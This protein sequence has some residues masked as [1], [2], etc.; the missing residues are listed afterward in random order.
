VTGQ[1]P[2]FVELGVARYELAG[3]EGGPLFDP[4]AHGVEPDLI[5]SACWRG[6][7]CWYRIKADRMLLRKVGLGEPSA[8]GREL[9]AG[10]EV[11]GAAPTRMGTEVGEGWGVDGLAVPIAFT[12]GLLLGR[13][14]VRETYVH[15]GFPAAWQYE[16]VVE[17]LLE[18]GVVTARR[19][20]PPSSPSS[21]SGS[22]RGASRAG[23]RTRDGRVDRPD[24]HAR[25]R[26]QRPRPGHR[27]PAADLRPRPVTGTLVE[28]HTGAPWLRRGRFS[29]RAASRG[30]R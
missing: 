25:L 3:V 10:I 23:R 14:F 21:A 28:T 12:G 6:C 29:G 7:V 11:R 30:F 20:A 24:V 8:G 2:D 9:L 13:G 17:L 15:M 5:S 4:G 18:G 1:I 19:I 16:R 22:R 26:L 27:R